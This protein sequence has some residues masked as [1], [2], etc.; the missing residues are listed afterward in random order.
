MLSPDRPVALAWRGSAWSA[1]SRGGTS[2][3]SFASRG[4]FCVEWYL[5]GVCCGEKVRAD[6]GFDLHHRNARGSPGCH[7]S[8]IKVM[9]PVEGSHAIRQSCYKGVMTCA[10]CNAA[11]GCAQTAGSS[12]KRNRMTAVRKGVRGGQAPY[13]FV[14]KLTDLNRKASMST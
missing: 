7:D 1:E 11:G 2:P 9:T 13:R 5:R 14:P 10:G 4:V 6:R 3:S 12:C 8:L